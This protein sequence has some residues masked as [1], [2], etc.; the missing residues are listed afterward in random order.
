MKAHSITIVTHI[1]A[2]MPM[3]IYMRVGRYRSDNNELIINTLPT[4]PSSSIS[5]RPALSVVKLHTHT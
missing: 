1:Y 2:N 5:V 3:S 4:G